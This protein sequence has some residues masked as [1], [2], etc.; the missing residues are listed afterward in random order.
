[1]VAT[2][3]QAGWRRFELWREKVGRVQFGTIA[4]MSSTYHSIPVSL[5]DSRNSVNTLDTCHHTGFAADKVG[6]LRL[7]DWVDF[8]ALTRT[9]YLLQSTFSSASAHWFPCRSLRPSLVKIVSNVLQE[10]ARKAACSVFRATYPF[11]DLLDCGEVPHAC[12]VCRKM[13]SPACKR[14][15]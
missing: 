15:F 11:R 10:R 7:D 2:C 1:M 5:W 13:R 6:C 3:T 4:M 8:P 9:S 14:N 12:E